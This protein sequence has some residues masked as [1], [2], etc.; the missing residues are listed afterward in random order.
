[1]LLLGVVAHE[2]RGPRISELCAAVHPDVISVDTWSDQ[3]GC[4]DNHLAVLRQLLALGEHG[5]W[6]AVLED[7]AK[8]VPALRGQLAEALPCAP[9]PI[10]SLYMGT[11]NP[12]GP[13]QRE[14]FIP[15]VQQ[16]QHQGAAWVMAD[17]LIG[18]VGYVVPWDVLADLV[19]ELE[20]RTGE[21]PLRMTR[22]AQDLQLPVCYTMPSLVDHNDDDSV[23]AATAANRLPRRAHWFGSA[24]R[25]NTGTVAMTAH[26]PPW[27]PYDGC[28]ACV[29]AWESHGW[30]V[31]QDT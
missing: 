27:S 22:W 18:S 21:L 23:N 1:M 4:E 7:D 29:R 28:G 6:C 3:L 14:A 5:D 2:S 24:L 26:I 12:S 25:W 30:P 19:P 31:T 16:A 10:V 9:A 11:G 8:P 20:L 17:A 15:A 13:V